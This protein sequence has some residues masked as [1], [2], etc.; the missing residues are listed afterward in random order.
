MIMR[1]KKMSQ[2]GALLTLLMAGLVL[3]EEV[4]S[5]DFL[6]YLVAFETAG[7]EW[8]DPEELEMMAQLNA[9]QDE[10]DKDE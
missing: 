2:W 1:V 7:G 6:D 4:L 10:G 8:V 3:A 9:D 5:K